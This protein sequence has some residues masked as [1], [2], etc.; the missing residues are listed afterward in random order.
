M[1]QIILKMGGEEKRCFEQ[2]V[3]DH[4]TNKHKMHIITNILVCII[5]FYPPYFVRM[6]FEYETSSNTFIKS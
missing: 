4:S 3:M 2:P 5:V 6:Y 1:Q